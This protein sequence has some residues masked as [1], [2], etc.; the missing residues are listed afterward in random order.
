M[1]EIILTAVLT[2]TA[3]LVFFGGMGVVVL[4]FL[5]ERKR[6]NPLDF[7]VFKIVKG[8]ITIEQFIGRKEQTAEGEF[9]VRVGFMPSSVKE[10][11]TDKIEDDSKFFTEEKRRYYVPLVSRDGVYTPIKI[12]DTENA[13]RLVPLLYQNKHF[14]IKQQKIT[15]ELTQK[16]KEGLPLKMALIGGGI[17][18]FSLIIALTIFVIALTQ[19]PDVV[20][21]IATEQ[22]ISVTNSTLPG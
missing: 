12:E 18:I 1:F 11:L 16:G 22:V 3:V 21:R 8:S 20:A 9:Y 10:R 4:L 2:F 6:K 14:A 7:A 17:I 19:T 13:F 15:Y 5:K